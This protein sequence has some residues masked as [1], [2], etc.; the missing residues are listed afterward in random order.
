MFDDVPVLETVQEL[1]DEKPTFD[2]MMTQIKR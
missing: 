1:I 2:Q